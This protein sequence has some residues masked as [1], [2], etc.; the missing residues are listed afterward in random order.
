MEMLAVAVFWGMKP[1]LFLAIACLVNLPGLAQVFQLDSLPKGGVLIDKGW[2]WQV[3]NNPNWAAPTFDDSHWDTIPA[4]AA[5]DKL[6]GFKQTQAGWVRVSVEVGPALTGRPLAVRIYQRAAAV[7]YLDGKL[8]RTF[9]VLDTSGR[10]KVA[11]TVHPEEFTALPLLAAGR[12]VIA[13]RITYQ[14]IPWYVPDGIDQQ[15]SVFTLRV[16]PTE[17]LVRQQADN[18]FW[19]GTFSHGM[20]AIFLTLL[21]VHLFYYVYRRQRINL[22]FGLTM[23][24]G[25]A[26]LALS[27]RYR[28]VEGPITQEWLSLIQ[29]LLL[30]LYMTSLL[31]TYHVYFRQRLGVFFW[32]GT[33]LMVSNTLINSYTNF[34]YT[35]PLF[36]IGIGAM[37]AA[38]MSLSVRALKAKRADGWITLG[39]M[40]LLIVAMT[41]QLFINIL[42]PQFFKEYADTVNEITSRIFLLT[43]PLTLALLL[44]RENAQTNIQLALN[45]SEVKQ[46]SEE[47]E[48][49]LTQQ[50]A[51]LEEQVSTRTAELSQSLAE[52]R[53][54]QQQLVQREKMASL[55]ELTAGIAHEIQNPLNFVNNFTEVSTELVDEL[56]EEKR[57][58]ATERDEA[59]EIELLGDLTQNLDKIGFHGKRASSIVRGMLEHSRSSTGQRES[60][61]L[62][63]LAD[64]YLRLSYHGLRAKDKL[65]NA[66]L[67]VDLNPALPLVS[68]VSQDVGRVLLNLYN[69]AFY[70]V[71]QRTLTA[72][73]GYEPTVSVKTKA[74]AETVEIWISD[75]GTGIPAGALG[76]I[77]QPFFTTKPTG[78][79]TG[80]G[81]SLSYDIIT[82]GH[83][84]TLRV[85]SVEG[86][87]TTL[88][89]ALPV[90]RPLTLANNL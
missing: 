49:I 9:G 40:S 50:K 90:P 6:R 34:Q 45:L 58:P 42:F 5:A 46:L 52:L 75:N 25:A 61:D 33:A 56:Q 13:A 30:A 15:A 86:E 51:F 26:Y 43:V 24:L 59:L 14:P 77:F 88:V 11:Q 12:H 74:V 63:A 29:G 53:A 35:A 65:F 60:T 83:G 69:N 57:K 79:G 72:P 55:G 89:V 31:Y 73:A 70:A 37:F 39:S 16:A 44:A 22:I 71:Q 3:G 20:V 81:L 4:F 85:E 64:E 78:Q 80:L 84:G 38:G 17:G 47:K 2:R 18:A 41:T 7:I 8:L 1:T 19:Q 87:G 76:K 10:L 21:I 48:A 67:L 32:L 68:V 23:L 82:K 28:F 27:V 36:S 62:N 54:T 66:K